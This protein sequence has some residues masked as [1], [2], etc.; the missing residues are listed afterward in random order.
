[1]DVMRNDM[2]LRPII[3]A[4]ITKVVIIKA[5]NVATPAPDKNKYPSIP[6]QEHINAGIRAGTR[7]TI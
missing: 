1:M 4:S 5:R 6:N 3:N 7:R 2:A